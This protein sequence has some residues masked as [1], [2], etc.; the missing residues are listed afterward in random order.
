MDK[1]GVGSYYMEDFGTRELDV[2]QQ[3][4][5]RQ[6]FLKIGYIQQ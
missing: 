6:I 4:V 1:F 2:Q 3:T 5:T